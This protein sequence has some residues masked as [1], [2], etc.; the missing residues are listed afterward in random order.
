MSI[1]IKILK[2]EDAAVLNI[3]AD[4]FDHAVLP[5]R[6]K[7]FLADPRHHW[8]TAFD[9]DLM[10]GFV[11]AVDYLH[12]DKAEAELWINEVGVSPTHSVG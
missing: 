5:Q 7:D 9:A 10:I 12:P 4:L 3:D 11:S 2:L 8:I 1:E 6:C